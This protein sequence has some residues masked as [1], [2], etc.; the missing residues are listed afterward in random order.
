MARNADLGELKSGGW[1]IG[2]P[3]S[4]ADRAVEIAAMHLFRSFDSIS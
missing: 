3:I 2:Y 4:S 1:F